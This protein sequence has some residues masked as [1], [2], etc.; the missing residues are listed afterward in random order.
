MVVRQLVSSGVTGQVIIVGSVKA[1]WPL[2]SHY[3]GWWTSSL[4]SSYPI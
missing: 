1:S 3:F 4:P 2:I